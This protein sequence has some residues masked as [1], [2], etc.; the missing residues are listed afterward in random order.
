MST[1]LEGKDSP[2]VKRLGEYT[3]AAMRDRARYR[4]QRDKLKMML[5]KVYTTAHFGLVD[6]IG[7][8]S[9]VAEVEYQEALE[10]IEGIIETL[11]EED[12]TG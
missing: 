3:R 1:V 7:Q 2:Y 11:T 4:Q 10:E 12:Y 8:P 9:V 6:A 5:D